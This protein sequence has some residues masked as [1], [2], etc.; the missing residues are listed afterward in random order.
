[1]ADTITRAEKETN[2]D[3]T[4]KSWQFSYSVE[5]G[6]NKN[7]FVVVVLASEMTDATDGTEAKTLANAKAVT[8]KAAWVA[9][10]AA[11]PT[12]DNQAGLEGAVTL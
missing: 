8:K 1:M 3:T 2:A 5:S 4:V 12:V 9:A 11:Q 10:L 7:S 6:A